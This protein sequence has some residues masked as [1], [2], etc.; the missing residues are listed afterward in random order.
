MVTQ[1]TCPHCREL[2][3]LDDESAMSCPN[4]AGKLRPRGASAAAGN[5]AGGDVDAP[6]ALNT[7]VLGAGLE[8]VKSHYNL[9]RSPASEASFGGKSVNSES[10]TDRRLKRPP[11]G[12]TTKGVDDPRTVERAAAKTQARKRKQAKVKSSLGVAIVIGVVLLVA[13]AAIAFFVLKG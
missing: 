9:E 6:M 7:R 5:D 10:P 4:C 8:P 12:V 1:V 11:Q 3:D 13:S 2:V